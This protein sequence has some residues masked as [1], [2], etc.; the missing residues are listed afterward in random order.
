MT[1]YGQND[2]KKKVLKKVIFFFYLHFEN[3]YP[4]M[5]KKEVQLAVHQSK[6]TLDHLCR[7]NQELHGG[8]IHRSH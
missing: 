1:F 8:G 7:I 6:L 2:R 4:S 5:H 3:V